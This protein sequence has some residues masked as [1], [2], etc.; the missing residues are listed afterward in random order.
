MTSIVDYIKSLNP[1]PSV[2]LCLLKYCTKSDMF[3]TNEENG[4]SCEYLKDY[5]MNHMT[6]FVKEPDCILNIIKLDAA[7]NG[8]TYIYSPSFVALDMR[9]GCNTN[10]GRY[11]KLTPDKL[12]HD[13]QFCL[14]KPDFYPEGSC[15]YTNDFDMFGNR[16][17]GPMYRNIDGSSNET[18]F[19][20]GDIEEINEILVENYPKIESHIPDIIEY[21]REHAV[22]D[23]QKNRPLDDG[24]YYLLDTTHDS[25]DGKMGRNENIC[26]FALLIKII[27]GK[28]EAKVYDKHLYVSNRLVNH[29]HYSIFPIPYPTISTWGG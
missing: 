11:D 1:V 8:S 3:G 27:Y 28:D 18:S 4:K 21:F 25:Y 10:I 2:Y 23:I 6:L 19:T 26:E 16:I 24:R 9:V 22:Y 14:F 13:K 7:M 12:T 29:W 15:I 17:S 5:S 20:K